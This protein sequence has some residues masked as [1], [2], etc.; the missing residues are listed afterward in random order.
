MK[1]LANTSQNYSQLVKKI[2]EKIEKA[3]QNVARQK[4]EMCWEIGKLVEENLLTNRDEAYGQNLILRLEEDTEISKSSLYKMRNFYQTY[5]DIPQGDAQ[6]NWSHYRVL[7]GIENQDE[8]SHFEKL[9]QKNEW[10]GNILQQKVSEKKAANQITKPKGKILKTTQ[11][12]A[13][14]RGKLFHYKLSRLLKSGEMAVDLGF[15]I[16]TPVSTVFSAGDIV[17]SVL[18][19][20]S[21][22]CGVQ[23]LDRIFSFEKSSIKSS[24]IHTYKATL[25]KVVDGD[26]IRVELDLGFGVFHREILR[27]GKINTPERGTKEGTVATAKLKQILKNVETLIIKTNKTDIYGRYIA[28]VFLENPEGKYLSQMLLDAGV[29]EVF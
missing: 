27:L 4:V 17:E 14:T 7:A 21:T 1:N 15:G 16:F 29:A 8:R 18:T 5:P 12:L 3:Q 6:L 24:K 20:P 13:F 2:L 26:T 11:Q 25:Q 9:I 19:G 22:C 10:S 28:D 23:F